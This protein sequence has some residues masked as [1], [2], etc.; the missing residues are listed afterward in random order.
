MSLSLREQLLKAGFVSSKQVK[1]VNKEKSKQQKMVRKGQIELDT[2]LQDQVKATKQAKA[3]RDL[4]LN[5]EQQQKLAKKEIKA[6]IKQLITNT[7]L[8][9]IDG[10]DY[11]N[12]AHNGKIKRIAVNNLMREK[13]ANGNL[14]IVQFGAGYEVVTYDVALKIKQRNPKIIVLLNDKTSQ[15]A[16]DPYAAY[17]IPDDLMW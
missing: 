15:D 3:Q 11:Y 17:K 10:D 5:A 2:S 13:L 4:E 12:F 8:P 14:A 6:Q 9:K 7:K 16:D 1:A